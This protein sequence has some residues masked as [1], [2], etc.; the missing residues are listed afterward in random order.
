[1]VP[2]LVAALEGSFPALME[3]SE[4]THCAARRVARAE[5]GVQCMQGLW[6]RVYLVVGMLARR[7]ELCAGLAR[8]VQAGAVSGGGDDTAGGSGSGGGDSGLLRLLLHRV[9]AG[10]EQAAPQRPAAAQAMANRLADRLLEYRCFWRAL[11]AACRDQAHRL[12]AALGE[13]P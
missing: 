1:M 6:S 5:E 13:V 8:A 4:A 11:G 12:E 7:R 2:P 3:R 9:W 10:P